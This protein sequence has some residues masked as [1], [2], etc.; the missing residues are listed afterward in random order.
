MRQRAT[1]FLAGLLI[2]ALLAAPTLGQVDPEFERILVPVFTV[3]PLA[4]ARGSL[5]QTDLWIRNNGP[6]PVRIYGYDYWGCSMTPCPLLPGAP[7]ARPFAA[8]RPVAV[9]RFLMVER[10]RAGQVSINL[11]VV[12][13]SSRD[14]SEGTEIPTPREWEFRAG[15][16][17]L[18]NVPTAS[19]FRRVLRIY[20]GDADRGGEVVVRV[21]GANPAWRNPDFGAGRDPLLGETSVFLS[22]GRFEPPS[23]E[24]TQ[25]PGID[26]P[27]YE[28]VTVLIE[29]VSPDLRIWAFL[30]LVHNET[31]QLT[32]V[33]PQ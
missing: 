3:Y 32:V 4:G 12:S 31:Q 14:V 13:L 23:T 17:A 27:Q 11:R 2:G 30:S 19:S 16:T 10:A 33:S 21:R 5:W 20:S 9:S 15:V 18:M 24:M 26:S 28:R 6:E 25:L 22:P 1:P 7:P 29:P 8:S